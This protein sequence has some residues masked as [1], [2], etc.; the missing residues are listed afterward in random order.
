MKGDYLFFIL[1]I[2]AISFLVPLSCAYSH[3]NDL[4]EADFLTH[5]KKYEAADLEDL[6]VD[7]QVLNWVAPPPIPVFLFLEYDFFSF[8]LAASFPAPLIQPTSTVL[9]C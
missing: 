4:I 8:L 2:F 3:Y 7:K 9:R 5:G 6:C 1:L